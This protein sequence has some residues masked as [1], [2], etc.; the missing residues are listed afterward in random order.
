[1]ILDAKGEPIAEPSEAVQEQRAKDAPTATQDTSREP[2]QDPAR[3]WNAGGPSW[4]GR[5]GGGQSPA[6][7]GIGLTKD[8]GGPWVVRDEY[9][10]QPVIGW[11]F[12]KEVAGLMFDNYC[13]QVADRINQLGPKRRKS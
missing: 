2:Q 10:A 12:D 5:A 3:A 4:L 6:P 1:M 7:D 8:P 13:A 9:L 11:S